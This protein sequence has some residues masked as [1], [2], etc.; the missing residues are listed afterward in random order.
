MATGTNNVITTAYTYL[1]TIDSRNYGLAFLGKQ[2]TYLVSTQSIT[3]VI[4]GAVYTIS[5]SYSYT[6]D[7]QGRVTQQVESSG[8]ATYTTSYSY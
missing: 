1:P 8:T 3:Q 6:F 4:S 2:N 5:Y 7:S